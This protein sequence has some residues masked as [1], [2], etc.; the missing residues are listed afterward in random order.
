MT[1]TPKTAA[2]LTTLLDAE[3]RKH[4]VCDGVIVNEVTSVADERL[5]FTW[6]ATIARSSDEPVLG[7]CSRIFLDALDVL[8]Q[9]YDL[10]VQSQY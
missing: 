3:L 9:K 4:A 6:T 2:E 1:K 10:Q 7:D 5:E 8:Q